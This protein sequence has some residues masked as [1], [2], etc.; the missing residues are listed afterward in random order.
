MPLRADLVCAGMSMYIA[1]YT[2]QRA[3]VMRVWGPQE[4]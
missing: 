3:R 1:A 2:A 4:E